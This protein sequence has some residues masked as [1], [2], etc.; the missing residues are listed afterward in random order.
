MNIAGLPL[1]LIGT[2]VA[3]V[4]TFLVFSYLLGDLPGLGG[5]FKG[6]YRLAMHIL[7]GAGVAYAVAVAWWS[8]IYP[9][10]VLRLIPAIIT[11]DRNAIGFYLIGV[12][13]GVLLWMKLLR[14]WAWLGNWATGYLVGVGLGVTLGGAVLGTL[15]TQAQ[16]TASFAGAGSAFEGALMLIATLSVLAAFT[17][18]VTTRRGPLALVTRAVQGLSVVGRFFIYVALGAAFAGVYA[19]SVAVLAGRVQ[20]LIQAVGDIYKLLS[21]S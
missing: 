7:I 21:G 17:F 8:V 10:V 12:L 15:L 20:F 2:I 18:T 5:L 9:R 6:F 1:D 16:S 19:A 11:V 4:L 14:R 13:I 3:A